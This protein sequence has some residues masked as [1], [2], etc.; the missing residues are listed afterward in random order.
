VA[1]HDNPVR[2]EGVR[3]AD[4]AADIARA[5]RAVQQHAEETRAG[6]DPVQVVG[7][8]LDHGD[9]LRRARFFL[10][11]FGQQAGRHGDVEGGHVGQHGPRPG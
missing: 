1:G 6:R 4:D 2:A 5:G 7:W 10:A 11:E 3:R 8:H 9:Q